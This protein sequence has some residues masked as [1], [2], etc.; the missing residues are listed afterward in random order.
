MTLIGG[1]MITQERLKQVLRYDPDTGDFH[2][3]ERAQGRKIDHPAGTVFSRKHTCYIKIKIDGGNY[4]AHRLAWLYMTG[5]VPVIIDHI[6]GSGINNKF[7]NFRN[8]ESIENNRNMRKRFKTISGVFGVSPINGKWKSTIS[9]KNKSTYIGTF[10]EIWDAICARK[11]KEYEL[12]FHFNHGKMGG[13]HA[14]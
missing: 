12:G 2:W 6:D 4:R 11:S 10:F 8:V 1:S 3:L 9:I 5:E 13:G 14:Q 7:N